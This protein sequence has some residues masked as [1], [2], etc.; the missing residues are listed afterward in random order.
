[1]YQL[2]WHSNPKHYSNPPFPHSQCCKRNHPH[3]HAVVPLDQSCQ[4]ANKLWPKFKILYCD[5][6]IVLDLFFF[7]VII[8]SSLCYWNLFFLFLFYQLMHSISSCAKHWSFQTHNID[9]SSREGKVQPEHC[10]ENRTANKIN[11]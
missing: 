2:I 6:S 5:I 8:I 4:T 3:T 10:G 11:Q 7:E 9:L 1:M